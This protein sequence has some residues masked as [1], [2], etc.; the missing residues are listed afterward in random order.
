[1]FTIGRIAYGVLIMLLCSIF[2]VYLFSLP[3][4]ATIGFIASRLVGRNH[5]NTLYDKHLPSH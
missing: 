4:M 5:H 2:T 1:M 3:L